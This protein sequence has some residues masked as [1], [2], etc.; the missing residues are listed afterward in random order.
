VYA[1]IDREASTIARLHNTNI[2]HVTYNAYAIHESCDALYKLDLL[3]VRGPMGHEKH[4]M[5]RHIM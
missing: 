3:E 1:C 5:Y 4:T 2:A